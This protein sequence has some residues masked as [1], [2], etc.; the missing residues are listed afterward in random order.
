MICNTCGKGGVDPS[1]HDCLVPPTT[2]TV[3]ICRGDRM[4]AISLVPDRGQLSTAKA[5]QDGE[6]FTYRLVKAKR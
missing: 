5:S 1:T 3:R 6:L 4:T 2:L